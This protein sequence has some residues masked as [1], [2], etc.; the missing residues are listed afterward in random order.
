MT[1]AKEIIS[2]E[3]V[4]EEKVVE[5]TVEAELQ[6]EVKEE[7]EKPKPVPE[8]V[9]LSTYLELKSDLKELKREVK[10]SKSSEKQATALAGVEDISKKYP[11]VDQ[12]F[13]ADILA[14]ATTAAQ[15]KVDEK[16]TPILE[17]Q[18]NERKKVAFDSAF[19]KLYSKT[20]DE[21]PDLPKDID[22]ELVKTLALTPQY[23]NVPLK[24]ILSKMYGTTVESKESSE[25]DA[26]SASDRVEDMVSFDKITAEQRS[27]IMDDPKLR[28]KYF[29]W[30]DTQ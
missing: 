24:D 11:D 29:D 1:D 30:A 23:R 17:K 7:E 2:E 4:E 20:I 13:I 8:T 9:P 10:E 28:K 18:E 22:K 27:T 15:S 21:N 26:R 5:G 16:Y 3:V 14:S 19:N 25:T 6:E 12:D